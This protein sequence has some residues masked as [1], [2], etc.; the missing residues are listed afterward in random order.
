VQEFS[1]LNNGA[2][3]L[4]EKVSDELKELIIHIDD[5]DRHDEI[6]DKIK[7]ANLD[8]CDPIKVNEVLQKDDWSGLNLKNQKS[9][10]SG[11][12]DILFFPLKVV[13]G[14]INFLPMLIWGRIRKKIKDPVMVP[15][16][17]VGVGVFIFPIIYALQTLLVFLLTSVSI[18]AGFLLA[19]VVSLPLTSLVSNR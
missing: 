10:R 8:L 18:A 2:N 17:K 19:S 6:L 16:I 7:S 4:R 12:I 13:F 15:S 5:L 3:L 1:S 14:I 9:N 11:I